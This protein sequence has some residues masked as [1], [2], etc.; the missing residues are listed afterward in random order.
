MHAL[1]LWPA[2]ERRQVVGVFTDIDD[3]LTTAG[4]ITPDAL[5]ALGRLHQAGLPVIAVTGR[6]V[7]WSE[8]FARA[9]P[10]DAIVAEN[11][12]VA[13]VLQ[14]GRVSRRYLQDAA[15]RA[16]N[17]SRM[18]QVAAR[19]VREVPGAVL[20]QDSAGR[21]TDI[22][23][24]HSE[25][26]HL[27]QHAID[28]AVR[29]MQAEGMSATVSSIHINGWFGTHNKLVGARWIVQALWGRALDAELAQWVYVGD[30]T[31]DQ[32]M[33]EAFGNSIGVANIRRFVPE[34]THLPRYVTE[35]ERGAGFAEVVQALL[36]VP[37]GRA[38]AA[39]CA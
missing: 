39:A 9:W 30:S 18:Q 8:P 29:I 24:D 7:G 4:S 20:S 2:D 28:H 6:P 15:I 19:V 17:F 12:S 32:L 5:E 33:F 25:F 16:A 35:G 1:R 31:N 13:L 3:T 21:E 22:A 38:R 23:I 34:L 37:G 27:P 26:T 14:G 11:G 36:S 10:V